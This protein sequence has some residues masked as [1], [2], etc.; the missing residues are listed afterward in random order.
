MAE[1]RNLFDWLGISS[2][3]RLGQGGEAIVY[4]MDGERVARIYHPGTDPADV[5]AR[6]ALLDELAGSAQR[7]PFAIPAVLETLTHEGRVVTHRTQAAGAPGERAA[8]RGGGRR[9]R[10]LDPQPSGRGQRALAT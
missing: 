9:A 6:S 3:Q 1:P 7:V 8:G 10:R 4:A 5:A 2:D